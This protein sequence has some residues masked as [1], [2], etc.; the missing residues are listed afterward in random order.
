MWLLR[1]ILLQVWLLCTDCVCEWVHTVPVA[2]GEGGVVY[3]ARI[4]D[5]RLYYE[6]KWFHKGQHIFIVSKEHGQERYL[7]C[8]QVSMC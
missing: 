3:E 4:E 8:V 1:R 6:G 2:G 7:Y 5:S